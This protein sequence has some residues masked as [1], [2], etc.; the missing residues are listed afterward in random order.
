MR[1]R[2]STHSDERRTQ[3]CCHSACRDL[4]EDST[5]SFHKN[6]PLALNNGCEIPA[7]AQLPLLFLDVEVLH[8]TARAALSEHKRIGLL[9]KHRL[10]GRVLSAVSGYAPVAYGRKVAVA[11]IYPECGEQHCPQN[12]RRAAQDEIPISRAYP[13][14]PLQPRADH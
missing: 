12:Q 9:L 1:G 7:A 10:F 14:A 6:G 8:L 11:S 3:P 2:A 13:A 4:K 5:V